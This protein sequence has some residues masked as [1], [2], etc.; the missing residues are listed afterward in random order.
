MSSKVRSVDRDLAAGMTG[1][2]GRWEQLFADLEAQLAAGHATDARWEEAELTRAE[3]ARVGMADRFRAATGA[4][5]RV[6]PRT[7]DALEGVVTDATGS[8]VLLGLAGGRCALVPLG[9]VAVV[10]GLAT[11]AAPPAGR[12]EA[13]LGLGH[14]LRALSRD[15]A[16]VVVRTDA[17]LYAGRLDRVGSDH[18]DVALETPAG[19]VVTLSFACLV[20]VVSR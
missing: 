3:R 19:R 1:R 12:V 4:R 10:E 5:V 2:P 14:A 8:W 20:A 16:P 18:V 6:L 15:R 7:G 11:R 17:G 9:A 13:G